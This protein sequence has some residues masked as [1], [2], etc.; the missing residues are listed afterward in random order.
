MGVAA[1]RD[2]LNSAGVKAP[3]VGM[4]LVSSGSS[5]RRFPGPASAIAQELGAPGIPAIDLPIASAGSLFGM[6]I[7]AQLSAMHGNV[8]VIASEKM[9]P[10]AM[11][12]PLERGVAPL[13]GDGAGACLIGSRRP[14]ED[15]RLGPAL[16]RRF[17]RRSA[18]GFRRAAR[19]ERPVG[20]HAGIPQASFR[21]RRAA[22][23]KRKNRS[24]RQSVPDASSQSKPDGSRCTG[25]AR[26]GVPVLLQHPALRQYIIGVHAYRRRGMVA[27]SRA[28]SGRF[29]LLRCIRRGISL[30]RVVGAGIGRLI[31]PLIPRRALW[32]RV[33]EIRQER[34][35]HAVPAR[36]EHGNPYHQQDH[37]HRGDAALFVGQRFLETPEPAAI[38]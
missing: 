25:T 15:R 28:L 37:D 13:F 26:G 35:A 23:K 12:E 31:D 9:S 16:R 18:P 5:E 21:D 27:R 20:D 8:L 29:D 36:S 38:H 24:V 30:G 32:R 17:R 22:R 6:A 14:R 4:F 19:D 34:D 11:R 7:A 10:I 1:G 2:C 3:D 33:G